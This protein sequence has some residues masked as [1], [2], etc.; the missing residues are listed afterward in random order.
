MTMRAS[1][2]Q[3]SATRGPASTSS[4]PTFQPSSARTSSRTGAVGARV[5]LAQQ[6]QQP[7]AREQPLRPA[8][9]P[10]GSDAAERPQPR[11]RAR[12][13]RVDEPR[14]ERVPLVPRPQ[15]PGAEPAAHRVAQPALQVLDAGRDARLALRRP[16]G[17]RLRIARRLARRRPRR[18]PPA[19]APREASHSFTHSGGDARRHRAARPQQQQRQRVL[20]GELPRRARALERRA[21][22][23]RPASGTGRAPAALAQSPDRVLVVAGR[24]PRPGP[25]QL[26]RRGHRRRVGASASTVSADHVHTTPRAAVSPPPARRRPPR[27][28]RTPSPRRSWP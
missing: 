2:T 22:R 11:R 3:R 16:P 15:P 19:S 28:R 8:V 10:P 18:G 12:R 6:V 26:A 24:R 23:D 13:L 25:R 9:G 5:R 14:R 4:R 27:G 21:R 1:T 17:R 7:Q 20:A